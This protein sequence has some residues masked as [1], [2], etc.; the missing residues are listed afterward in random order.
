MRIPTL[1][2]LCVLMP[3]AHADTVWK[4]GSECFFAQASFNKVL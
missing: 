3:I 2:A 4:M 1:L